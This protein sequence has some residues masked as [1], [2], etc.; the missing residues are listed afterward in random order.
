MRVEPHTAYLLHRRKYRE[1]SAIL[2]I[3]SQQYGRVSCIGKGIFSER[4]NNPARVIQ[5]FQSLQMAWVGKS[6]LP[7][8]TTF[9]AGE[10]TFNLQGDALYCGM[11]VNELI[12]RLVGRGEA[13]TGL[14]SLYES[15]LGDLANQQLAV[16]QTLRRFEKYF[17]DVCGYGLL[18]NCEGDSG[19]PI[20]AARH[21]YYHPEHGPE[22]EKIAV[23]D[24]AVS[25]LM[26]LKFAN[27]EPLDPHE[28]YQA[29]QLMRHILSHYLGDKPLASRS[30]F[31]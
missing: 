16:E 7:T 20:D 24:I 19:E 1:T 11:Y 4:K 2:E 9:E 30:L 17:L 15:V 27:D 23:D 18:L 25:G 5:P 3:L 12:V 6:A 22:L 28:L 29:K 10:Q 31:A 14:F 26:L 8:V 13:N 21:Y